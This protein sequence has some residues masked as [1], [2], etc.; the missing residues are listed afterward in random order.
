MIFQGT[1]KKEAE[2]IKH[3]AY[4]EA[5][6]SEAKGISRASDWVLNV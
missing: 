6:E 2:T 1:Q 5:Q 3:G 4:L